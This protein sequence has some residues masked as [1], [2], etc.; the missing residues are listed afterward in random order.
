MRSNRHNCLIGN[1]TLRVALYR[2]H[3]A[4]TMRTI[5][6]GEENVQRPNLAT[7]LGMLCRGYSFF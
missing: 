2:I 5:I 1:P 6:I 7:S 4:R 3:K